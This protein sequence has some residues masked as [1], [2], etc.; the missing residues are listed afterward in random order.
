MS[1]WHIP[2]QPHEVVFLVLE[3]YDYDV[4]TG[5]VFSN[6]KEIGTLNDNG[7]IFIY[8]GPKRINVK[9]AHAIWWK[10]YGHWPTQLVDHEDQTK[11]ND[12][13]SNLRY[14]THSKNKMNGP[15]YKKKSGLPKGVYFTNGN[16]KN[17]YQASIRHK[18]KT[19]H[20]GFHPTPEA[21]SQTY[22]EA[23]KKFRVDQHF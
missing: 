16:G 8:G 12:S 5:R 1:D 17:P 21:A 2:V 22:R 14:L 9:R 10:H 6:G 11:T 15:A 3:T 19:V 13:I 23:V 7:Y 4:I 20:L 18:G